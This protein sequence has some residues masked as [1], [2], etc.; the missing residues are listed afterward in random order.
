MVRAVLAWLLAVAVAVPDAPKA[1][2]ERADEALIRAARAACPAGETD[3]CRAALRAW[4]T[5]AS[6]TALPAGLEREAAD[7]VAFAKN[8]GELRLFA[9]RV[10]D[11]IRV[12]VSDPAGAVDRIDV[13]IG[14]QKGFVRLGML[15]GGAQGRY[16][17]TLAAND[18]RECLI[19][20]V[21]T[22]FG[23]DVR[24]AR[25]VLRPS[26]VVVPTAPNP[27]KLTEN[28]RK[29]ALVTE[30]PKPRVVEDPLPWWVIAGG[31]V[32]AALVGAG[33]VQELR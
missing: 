20:A 28:V 14:T 7:A 3:R 32:A 17:Y 15:E 12:G 2:G 26:E 16:E 24:L 11:R 25:T 31:V 19:D 23:G 13:W 30:P 18:P 8:A 9:S 21:S 29:G 1:E 33:V 22:K 6:R 27:E 10:G 4:A 5:L